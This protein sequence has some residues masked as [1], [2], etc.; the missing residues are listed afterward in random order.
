M[1]AL[2]KVYPAL[3]EVWNLTQFPDAGLLS[4]RLNHSSESE[5]GVAIRIINEPGEPAAEVVLLLR[6][7]KNLIPFPKSINSKMP[8]VPDAAMSDP[9]FRTDELT[10]TAL[11]N[12]VTPALTNEPPAAMDAV[13]VAPTLSKPSTMTLAPEFTISQAPV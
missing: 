1:L 8:A 7:R 4:P 5:A 12:C 6:F 10:L 2:C 11:V 9:I 13:P 3:A